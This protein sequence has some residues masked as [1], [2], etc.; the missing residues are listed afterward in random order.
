MKKTIAVFVALCIT[1]LTGIIY[2]QNKDGNKEA[3]KEYFDISTPATNDKNSKDNDFNAILIITKRYSHEIETSESETTSDKS[4]VT[5]SKR[6]HDLKDVVE[7]TVK[8]YLKSAF[9]V[10]NF[11]A[12]ETIVS[13]TPTDAEVV[14][15]PLSYAETKYSYRNRSGSECDTTSGSESTMTGSR[16]MT[17]KPSIFGLLGPDFEVVFD[18]NKKAI[19]MMPRAVAVDYGFKQTETLRSRHWPME[20]NDTA[21]SQTSTWEVNKCIFEMNPVEEKGAEPDDETSFMD[22]REYMKGKISDEQLKNVPEMPIY[23]HKSLD[24][25][26][27]YKDL[28][29]T[30]GNGL[31]DFG[32]EGRKKTE[33][34]IKGGTETEELTYKWNMTLIKTK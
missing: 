10:T 20:E 28:E 33:K 9:V 4:C 3:L 31:T 34:Q 18:S 15:F 2:S 12:N 30:T 24:N 14:S 1:L 6:R 25:T 5:E 29:A 11:I 17:K 27:T 26:R 32:G 23:L 19:R 16:V 13:Y 7:S 22:L 8:I 21:R